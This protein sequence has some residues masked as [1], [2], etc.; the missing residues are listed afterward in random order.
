[1]M[2]KLMLPMALGLLGFSL[3]AAAGDETGEQLYAT[4]CTQC[5]GTS[6][7]GRGVNA[8]VMDVLPRSHIDP[9]EMG[10]RQDKDLHK[11]IREGGKSINKS[12]LMPA[13]GHNLTDEQIDKIVRH[14]RVLCCGATP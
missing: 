14:L 12:V 2:K 5:H 9:E 3:G 10:A 1:M 4:Y 13:W 8:A 6:G 7:D 11:V